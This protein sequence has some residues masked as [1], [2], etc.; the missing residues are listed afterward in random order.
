MMSGRLCESSRGCR[1]RR[2]VPAIGRYP[3]SQSHRPREPAPILLTSTVSLYDPCLRSISRKP[4]MRHTAVRTL[5]TLSSPR[6]RSGSLRCDISEPKQ[7]S[8]ARHSLNASNL[9]VCTAVRLVGDLMTTECH[10]LGMILD[11][12]NIAT[13][14]RHPSLEWMAHQ[15]AHILL[16]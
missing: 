4:I 1:L 3:I 12:S 2:H 15:P 14:L 16:F 6:Y 9:I 11:L 7:Q 8:T 13:V 5:H 10:L